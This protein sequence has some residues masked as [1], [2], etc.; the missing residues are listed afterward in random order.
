[1]ASSALI[2]YARS[3][4]NLTKISTEVFLRAQQ[5]F[6]IKLDASFKGTLLGVVD[7]TLRQFGHKTVNITDGE[8][9]V[10]LNRIIVEDCL[11]YVAQY[12]MQGGRS[13]G[14]PNPFAEMVDNSLDSQKLGR[15]V[16][17]LAAARGY[18]APQESGATPRIDFAEP[19]QDN[20]MNADEL[21]KKL[22]EERALAN[23]LNHHNTTGMALNEILGT[24]KPAENYVPHDEYN[25]RLESIRGR[26]A[27]AM[28]PSMQ[29]PAEVQGS[30]Q[31]FAVELPRGNPA[32]IPTGYL[33]VSGSIPM[34]PRRERS[35]RLSLDFRRHLHSR[36]GGHYVL[37]FPL[38]R[39]VVSINL[40][41]ANTIGYPVLAEDPSVSVHISNLPSRYGQSNDLFSQL[42]LEKEINGFYHYRAEEYE[43][44]I[45]GGAGLPTLSFLDI[46]FRTWDEH[47]IEMDE[48]KI[49]EIHGERGDGYLHVTCA[50]P[51][52][53][54]INDYISFQ[55][56][57]K[58]VNLA[59]RLRILRL[60]DEYSFIA[61]LPDTF[62]SDSSAKTTLNRLFPR[63]TLN[64]I[65]KV[66]A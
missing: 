17:N 13:A 56:K 22:A 31:D 65:L 2:N 41:S 33:P 23:N 47:P 4:A 57:G 38:L 40:E 59:Q 62:T 66:R 39:N 19:L 48:L 53:L 42:F 26:E 29:R 21:A 34:D 5:H 28:N 30:M 1:M 49:A 36:H 55:T 44:L 58:E 7:N 9:L 16:E 18:K 51:H 10:N 6:G 45:L 35:L 12:Q 61:S 37:R 63:I 24:E 11:K 8:H 27:G 15:M 64:F 3:P 60:H 14:N 20:R 52:H 46:S 50:E 25:R 32:A 43:P 54:T